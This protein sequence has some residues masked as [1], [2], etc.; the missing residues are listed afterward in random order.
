MTALP[1]RRQK[2]AFAAVEPVGDTSPV[3]WSDE[4]AV[5]GQMIPFRVWHLHAGIYCGLVLIPELD[6]CCP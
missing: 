1:S 2:S 3:R 6:G 4:V 5:V